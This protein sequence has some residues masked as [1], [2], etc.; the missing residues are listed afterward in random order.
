MAAH[1]KDLLAALEEKQQLLGHLEELLTLEQQAITALD[2]TQLDR[3]DQQKRQLLV[4]LEGNSNA[5]R[6]LIRSLADQA[7]LAP[8]ATLSPVIATLAAP[9]KDRCSQLQSALLAI[10]K[11]VD[12][13]LELNRELL[14]TSLTTVTTSL[15]FFNRIFSRGTTY[16]D[17]GKMRTNTNGVQL[18]SQEA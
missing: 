13:L 6:Q 8:T 12:R 15:E 3:L 16:G 17:A 1:A 2:L 4:E 18:V 10:G 5:T 7:N 9:L 11:R 14:Q